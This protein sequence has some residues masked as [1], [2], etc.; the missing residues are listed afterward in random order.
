MPV[1]YDPFSDEAM[2]DPT[3]LYAE[4]REEGA[5]HR[6][7][8]YR[9]WAL[10][11]FDDVWTASLRFEK[12]LD[13]TQGQTP[14]QVLLGEPVPRTFMTMNQPEHRKWRALLAADY[15]ADGVAAQVE[16]L[17]EL[18]REILAPLLAGGE[19]DVYRDFAN[20]VMCANAGHQL[21][22]PRADA[23]RVR[24][25]IDEMMHR[26]RGQVGATSPRNQ[27]AAAELHAYLAGFVAALRR[28]PG[29]ALR[30][31]RLLLEAEVD[32]RRLD[33]EELV[34]NLYSLLVTGSETTPM[35]VAGTF[36]QLAKHPEQKAALLADPGLARRAFLETAR[37]DQPTNMLAR[38]VREGFE[39]GGRKIAPG[40]SL[41]FLYASA[42]RDAAKFD[43][44][45]E[46]DIHREPRRDLT[47]GIGGHVCLGMHLA[48]SA[49]ALMIEELLDRI[50]DW[51]LVE[52]GCERAYGEHLRG[53]VRVPI[54]FRTRAAGRA[55]A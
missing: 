18:V 8:K 5:P 7:E 35:V 24:A 4:M 16:R 12:A 32:G 14:G 49:G 34:G 43:R 30:H 52:R 22:L 19:L 23:E 17:R 44:P 26:E 53:F 45:D 28:E 3:R 29:R 11:R 48:I 47:F 15:S 54:R 37:F 51:E 40:D 13:Y 10:A 9:A 20:R 42:N 41:L 46:Y 2:T 36:Y 6:I 38:R 21:G 55:S 25:L 33:D 50:E 39:L 1:D 27:R 31:T